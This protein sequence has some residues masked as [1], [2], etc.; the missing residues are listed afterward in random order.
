LRILLAEDNVSNQLIATS[1]L[2]R[3]GHRVDAV[4]NGR[5]AVEAAAALPYDLILMDVQMPEV[6]GLEA[7]RR[8]R[9]LVGPA[10]LTPIVALTANAYAQDE[11]AC[12]EAGM[13]GFLAKPF[14]PSALAVA[15]ARYAR[16]EMGGTIPSGASGHAPEPGA[17]FDDGV[18]DRIEQQIG[19]MATLK[20]GD[21]FRKDAHARLDKLDALRLDERGEIAR[22]AHAIKG[23][24]LSIGA[25]GL[26]RVADDLERQVTALDDA[27][28]AVRRAALRTAFE[29]AETRIL[30]RR[31][32][33]A[34][35]VTG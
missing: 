27:A 35:P 22:E 30:A 24:A 16:A 7:T 25:A 14:E 28:F 12:R 8:I 34:T 6:D 33:R 9:N 2:D 11:R 20:V 15:V 4:S 18:L 29:A 3:M 26:G 23:G 5:E 32:S 10:R 31:E 1:F 21:L 17:D 13:D 19:A